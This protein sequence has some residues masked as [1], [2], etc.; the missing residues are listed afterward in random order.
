MRVGSTQ[1]LI[2]FNFSRNLGSTWLFV[3]S[4]GI[5]DS[6]N[7]TACHKSCYS[8]HIREATTVALDVA[9]ASSRKLDKI[10]AACLT[11]LSARTSVVRHIP[12]N[13][14]TQ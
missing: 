13:T 4:F 5:V 10:A 9:I 11:H 7:H 14:N 12:I 2:Y 3:R 8:I 6:Q 1:I